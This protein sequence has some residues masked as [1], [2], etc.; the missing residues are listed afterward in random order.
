MVVESRLADSHD[1]R[2]LCQLRDSVEVIVG[3]VLKVL[4]VNSDRR[5]HVVILLGECNNAL[6]VIK[7]YGV[8]H[9]AANALVGQIAEHAVP[10]LIEPAVVVVRVSVEDITQHIFAPAGIPSI[11]ST[12]SFSSLPSPSTADRIIPWLSTPQSFTGLR[13]D[14]KSIFLP[15][16]SSG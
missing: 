5:V 3:Q 15:T 14:T 1:L 8:V 7:V 6:C 13:F 2:V 9:N 4:G 10:V 16:S 11:V 12:W